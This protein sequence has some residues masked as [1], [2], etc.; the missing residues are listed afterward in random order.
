VLQGFNSQLVMLD[1]VNGDSAAAGSRAGS[2]E[3]WAAPSQS[4]PSAPDEMNDESPI[5]SRTP[6]ATARMAAGV[7]FGHG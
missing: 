3:N 1:R 7:R 4:R 6:A 5:L 2:V